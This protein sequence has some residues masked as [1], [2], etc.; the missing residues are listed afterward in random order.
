M[1]AEPGMVSGDG[2]FDTVLMEALPGDVISKGGAEG[3]EA[4]GLPGRGIGIAVKMEDGSNRGIPPVV[5]AL[6]RCLGALPGTLPGSL[7]ALEQVVV[8][9]TRGEPVGEVRAV[10]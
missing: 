7:A 1:S 6:L 10:S 8:L 5:L 2:G 4:A 9:N 3:C